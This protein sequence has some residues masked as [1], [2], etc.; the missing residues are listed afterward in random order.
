MKYLHKLVMSLYYNYK[1][2]ELD[3]NYLLQASEFAV[4]V[5]YANLLLEYVTKGNEQS[6]ELYGILQ[7]LHYHLNYGRSQISSCRL[8]TN[9]D[10]RCLIYDLAEA[11]KICACGCASVSCE[12]AVK[13]VIV[14]LAV[15]SRFLRRMRAARLRCCVAADLSRRKLWVTVAVI[16]P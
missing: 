13:A 6:N 11:E 9:D 2:I 3:K 15:T 4:V 7:T 14:K 12:A 1:V 8:S 10:Y 5:I 16:A